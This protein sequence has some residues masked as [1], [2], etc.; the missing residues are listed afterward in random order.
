VTAQ[1]GNPK[2]FPSLTTPTFTASASPLRQGLSAPRKPTPTEGRSAL[3]GTLTNP[4]RLGYAPKA[5]AF[6]IG[7]ELM[8]IWARVGRGIKHRTVPAPARQ[9][10]QFALLK[11]WFEVSCQKEHEQIVA[12]MLVTDLH[13]AF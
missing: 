12:M 8:D 1:K 5:A 13:L 4:S 7:I 6:G 9:K 2:P 3:C 11:T 10:R